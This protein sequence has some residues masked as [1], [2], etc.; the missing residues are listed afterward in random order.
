VPTLYVNDL[1]RGAYISHTLRIDN[2]KTPLEALVEI[3]R[4]MR[5]GEPPPRM[6][7]RTCSSTCSSPSTATTCRAWAA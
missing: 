4:M 5:P 6:P 2:T 1:D 3:Y 7:R